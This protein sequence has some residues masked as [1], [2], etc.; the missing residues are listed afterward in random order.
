MSEKTHDGRNDSSHDQ[1]VEVEDS[2]LIYDKFGFIFCTS[3]GSFTTD[4]LTKFIIF[5]PNK[6]E[7][8]NKVISDFE[9]AKKFSGTL[10]ING[11]ELSPKEQI[12]SDKITYKTDSFK[13]F[14]RVFAPTS[15]MT[16]ID[17]IYSY[18]EQPYM[19]IYLNNGSAKK[20]SSI[21]IRKS[22]N[23]VTGY[24]KNNTPEELGNAVLEAFKTGDFKTF[25]SCFLKMEDLKNINKTEE[26]EKFIRDHLEDLQS[27]LKDIFYSIRVSTINWEKVVI[28]ECKFEIEKQNEFETADYIDIIFKDNNSK[29]IIRLDD[30]TKLTGKWLICDKPYLKE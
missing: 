27:K 8:D 16:E 21:V 22:N 28:V 14:K 2:Y 6:R 26:E 18:S 15:Y 25:Q 29:H 13:L 3:N 30:C 9:P 17:M 19:E 5:F 11:V 7:F 12:V 24:L 4:E 23:L 20:V 10:T 1:V